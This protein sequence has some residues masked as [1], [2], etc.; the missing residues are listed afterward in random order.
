ML[1]LVADNDRTFL[2]CTSGKGFLRGHIAEEIEL[3]RLVF[4]RVGDVAAKVGA[5]VDQESYIFATTAHINLVTSFKVD[6]ARI[7][8]HHH[9]RAVVLFYVKGDGHNL[10]VGSRLSFVFLALRH[11][12]GQCKSHQN[13]TDFLHFMLSFLLLLFLLFVYCCIANTGQ[14]QSE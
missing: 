2:R 13:H 3:Q 4:S 11:R 7:G 1:R 6:R 9:F 5:V 12:Y 10:V 14:K 8:I